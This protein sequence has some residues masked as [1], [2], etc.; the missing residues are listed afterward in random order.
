ME[1]YKGFIPLGPT[2][3]VIFLSYGSKHQQLAISINSDLRFPAS[4]DNFSEA[5][6]HQWQS[7]H[8][9]E[10]HKSRQK[11]P[12]L[13]SSHETSFRRSQKTILISNSQKLWVENQRGSKR[14]F[15]SLKESQ[16]AMRRQNALCYPMNWRHWIKNI[17][18]KRWK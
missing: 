14:S 18:V 2:K 1:R 13:I 3:K 15:W 12:R 8:I 5:H 10:I 16:W 11:H 7:R 17:K 9:H 4:S 6:K